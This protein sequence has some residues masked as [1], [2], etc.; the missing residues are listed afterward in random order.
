MC[1]NLEKQVV[2]PHLSALV[3]KACKTEDACSSF[4]WKAPE[5]RLMGRLDGFW[6]RAPLFSGYDYRL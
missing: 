4:L 6:V 1:T 2:I 5:A 3:I